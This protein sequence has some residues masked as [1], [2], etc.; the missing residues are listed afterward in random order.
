[1]WLQAGELISLCLRFCSVKMRVLIWVAGFLTLVLFD[2]VLPFY[3]E[4]AHLVS[5]LEMGRAW[6]L[7]PSPCSYFQLWGSWKTP[8]LWLGQ[9][10]VQGNFRGEEAA[11]GLEMVGGVIGNGQ[12][13]GRGKRKKERHN[14]YTLTPKALP[15]QSQPVS[16]SCML[17]SGNMLRGPTV[18]QVLR[19]VMGLEAQ[20]SVVLAL[21][22]LLLFPC[23]PWTC[24]TALGSP[25]A[26]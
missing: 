11:P 22:T 9:L 24:F 8:T 21:R 12:G 16:L 25:E 14:H 1:M 3:A 6:L 10:R 5:E 19:E 17:S 15:K 26:H 18:R 4:M 20:V 23:S 2:D 13:N 7:A